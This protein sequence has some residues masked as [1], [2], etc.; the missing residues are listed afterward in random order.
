MTDLLYD[1][2]HLTDR[3][4]LDCNYSKIGTIAE[5]YVDEA[6]GRPEWLAIKTGLFGTTVTFAPLTGAHVYGDDVVV[7]YDASL[8]KDAPT[9]E[10]DRQLTANEELDLYRHYGIDRRPMTGNGGRSGGRREG[11]GDRLQSRRNDDA[12]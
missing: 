2:R 10:A 11:Q 6:T 1:T 9:V 3:T 7:R 12:L 4:A 8:V 5:V